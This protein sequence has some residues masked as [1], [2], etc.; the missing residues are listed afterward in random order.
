MI[1]GLIS[2]A[3]TSGLTAGIGA[4]AIVRCAGGSGADATGSVAGAETDCTGGMASAVCCTLPVSGSTKFTAAGGIACAE[5]AD[6]APA[7]SCGLLSRETT[8]S[9]P[10]EKRDPTEAGV[11]LAAIPPLLVERPVKYGFL[12]SA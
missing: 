6:S 10:E 11:R 5:S 3:S 7:G 2:A 9:S 8:L 1:C 4:V 12:S